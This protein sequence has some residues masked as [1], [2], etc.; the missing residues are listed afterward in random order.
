VGEKYLN[1]KFEIWSLEIGGN[2]VCAERG[3]RVG[4]RC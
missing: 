3:V 2:G 1:L 4:A